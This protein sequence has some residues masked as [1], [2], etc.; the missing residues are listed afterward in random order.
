MH[1]IHIASGAA[2]DR[3]SAD[4]KLVATLE[5]EDDKMIVSAV[6]ADGNQVRRE[7][8]IWEHTVYE[9]ENLATALW[10]VAGDELARLPSQR[11]K[12]CLIGPEINLRPAIRLGIGNPDLGMGSSGAWLYCTS[13]FDPV[14]AKRVLV[15]VALA[16]D[17]IGGATLMEVDHAAALADKIYEVA[18]FLATRLED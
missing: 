14:G 3:H 9:L 5:F 18:K 4:N 17:G 6:G 12:D 1:T 13:G 7:A 2:P 8:R 15:R 16:W 10:L 11:S